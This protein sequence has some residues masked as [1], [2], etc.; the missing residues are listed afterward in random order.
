LD[1]PVEQL[2]ITTRTVLRIHTNIK[3]AKT[4]LGGNFERHCIAKAC[5]RG[6]AR[7]GGFR[8]RWYEGPPIDWDAL[9]HAGAQTSVETLQAMM[10]TMGSARGAARRV[11]GDA[12][13]RPSASATVPAAAAPG[14]GPEPDPGAAAPAM[15][16][17]AALPL[18]PLAN[19]AGTV[20]ADRFQQ[21]LS[22]YAGSH[23]TAATSSTASSSS[24]SSSSSSASAAAVA[25]A[26]EYHHDEATG[27]LYL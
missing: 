11:A 6:G 4:A 10:E 25:S 2:H 14:T 19:G 7:Y 9:E 27:T 20:P 1:V 17:I 8:W 5:D 24:S 15:H 18:G 22:R 13:E 23:V 26:N 12:V 21:L 16:S 3:N